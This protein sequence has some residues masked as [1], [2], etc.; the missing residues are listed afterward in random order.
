MSNPAGVLGSYANRQ[1]VELASSFNT[2]SSTLTTFLADSLFL[3]DIP[4]FLIR[5]QPKLYISLIPYIL[6][7]SI[8]MEPNDIFME[9]KAPLTVLH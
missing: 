7:K 5:T 6:F 8:V 1:D 4:S 9:R 3:T 2:L